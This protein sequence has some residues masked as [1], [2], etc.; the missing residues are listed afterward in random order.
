MNKIKIIILTGPYEGNV[1]EF[2]YDITIG[3]DISNDLA[4]PLD[5]T[6]SRKHAKIII[7]NKEIYITD[8]NS[9][10]G[11]FLITKNKMEKLKPNIQTS[12]YKSSIIKI[13]NTTFLIN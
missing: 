10:N 6:I 11:T 13:G 7:N 9:T 5:L 12:I 1:Y 8:L 3:R 2:E 4:L